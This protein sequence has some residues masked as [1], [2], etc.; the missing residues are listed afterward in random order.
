M[1]WRRGDRTVSFKTLGHGKVQPLL[2]MMDLS[3]EGLIDL[4]TRLLIDGGDCLFGDSGSIARSSSV[5][6]GGLVGVRSISEFFS[7]WVSVSA[8]KLLVMD[9]W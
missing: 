1:L 4:L 5:G 8:R 3:R 6:S 9:C 7:R 2:L